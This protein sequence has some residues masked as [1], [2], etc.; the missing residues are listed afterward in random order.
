MSLS[1]KFV[2]KAH[3]EDPQ[4]AQFSVY[5]I[6]LPT[7]SLLL[8]AHRFVT[9]AVCQCGKWRGR[10]VSSGRGLPAKAAESL[11]GTLSITKGECVLAPECV[12]GLPIRTTPSVHF[13]TLDTVHYTTKPPHPHCFGTLT[14]LYYT[15]HRTLYH[16]A[17]SPSLL[18]YTYYTLLH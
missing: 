14:T 18:W 8:T 4:T 11:H 13:T 16:Q 3:T 6:D 2:K 9:L 10:G 5:T 7:F 1:T 17:T 12:C 15:R